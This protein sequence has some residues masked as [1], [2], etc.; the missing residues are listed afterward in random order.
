MKQ[1]VVRGE[2]EYE[3][4]QS[5]CLNIESFIYA[6]MHSVCIDLNG[7]TEK[8]REFADAFERIKHESPI[9]GQAEA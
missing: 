5:V 9:Q 4:V 3:S 6:K 8:L 7:M 1:F 2:V